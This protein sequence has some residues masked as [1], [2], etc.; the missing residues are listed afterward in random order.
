[1]S[2]WSLQFF[3]Y[4]LR[5]TQNVDL[6]VSSLSPTYNSCR[7]IPIFAILGIVSIR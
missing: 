1:M 6:V 7:V 3:Q 4:Y 2:L 5:Q